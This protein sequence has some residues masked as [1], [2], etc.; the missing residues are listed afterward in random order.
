MA[1]SRNQL[2]QLLK[3]F[4]AE[5]YQLEINPVLTRPSDVSRGDFTTTIALQLAKRLGRP[6]LDIA[7][8]IAKT[9]AAELTDFQ[10]EA[11]APG[12]LNFAMNPDRTLELIA[13]IS[14]QKKDYGR[15]ALRD[16]KIQLEH[17]ALNINK[18]MHVGHLRNACLGDSLARLLRADGHTVEVLNKIDD[19]GEKA[20]NAL[21]GMRL[22]TDLK[23]E[24]Y[25]KFDHYAWDVYTRAATLL[26][27]DPAATELRD[28]M[29]QKLDG[30]D[31][32]F[33][34]FA[35]PIL[36]QIE[37]DQLAT[38][39]RLGIF[40][41]VYVSESVILM[42]KLWEKVR[43]TLEKTG[44]FVKETSGPNAGAWVIKDVV[45][46]PKQKLTNP[47]KILVKSNG[48]TTY[49]GKDIALHMWKFGLVETPWGYEEFA[50]QMNGKV[51]MRSAIF[52]SNSP[53]LSGRGEPDISRSPF[54]D[55]GRGTGGWIGV[56]G[57]GSA[58]IVLDIVDARQT[59]VMAVVGA[60]LA[61]LGYQK[62]AENYHHIPYEVVGLSAAA[63]KEFGVDIS[64]GKKFYT[65]EGSKGI[66]VKIDD[67]IDKV[68]EKVKA[69]QKESGRALS[70]RS[71]EM[72]AV[73][74]IKFYL[75]KYSLTQPIAFD[76]D[77]ALDFEGDTGPYLQ[78][79]HARIC[80]ILRKTT[81]RPPSPPPHGPPLLTKEGGG[82]VV[83]PADELLLIRKLAAYPEVVAQAAEQYEPHLLCGYL[84][85]L[86][87]QFN[88]FYAKYPVLKAESTDR[89]RRLE[90]ITA[91]AQVMKNGL[92]L[93]G[94]E[95]P[96][97]M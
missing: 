57:F 14:G 15:G 41:D 66:G 4:I 54:P 16:G 74:A 42:T 67:L 84:L 70:A 61:K 13:E 63:A 6:P 44:A 20:A 92:E 90:I 39:N 34:R 37:R 72:V 25:Q 40:Y 75:L 26:K 43:S 48:V 53:S 95:A 93:L 86:A 50:K 65:M 36:D 21:L 8:E 76:F 64:D 56:G 35:Q 77:A 97:E 69:K 38:M 12:F 49:S 17:T 88:R 3:Q 80:G 71:A 55:K 45:I 24:D 82:G 30:A 2:H 51:V 87:Q 1:A 79:T 91:V 68:L 22:V 94:I 47:D 28:G 31:A 52:P 10:I 96:E 59:Y 27:N 33:M 85:Q 83:P 18:A 29:L 46:D 19:T 9:L 73:G 23:K 32:E 81:P 89:N 78:Y 11:V 60:A 5:H 62:Q 58:S 7:K